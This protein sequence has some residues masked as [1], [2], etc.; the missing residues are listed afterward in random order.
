M[1]RIA[2][3]RWLKTYWSAKLYF[4]LGM[5]KRKNI[6]EENP[7][8]GIVDFLLELADYEK[9]VSRQMH[10]Y[11]AYRKAAGVIKGLDDKIESGKD[12]QKLEGV[13]KKM[14]LKIDEFLQTGK[15]RKLEDI[16]TDD[17]SVAIQK[18]AT[19]TGIG[20][21]GLQHLL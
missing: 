5:S 7:N 11:N 1:F 15:L 16:R 20:K 21:G 17:T 2:Q 18:L 10:K 8:S 19:V 14:A 12:A 4:C 3:Y 9:N 6:S 13:G